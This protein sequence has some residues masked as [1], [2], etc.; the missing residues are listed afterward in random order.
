MIT[1]TL[2]CPYC[3]STDIFNITYKLKSCN[4]CLK[5]FE[6]DVIW[7]IKEYVNNVV[8][9]VGDI[10]VKNVLVIKKGVLYLEEQ[11]F[12]ID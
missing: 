10:A 6:V 5:L 7:H 3:F 12:G 11:V 1:I 2:N 9:N 8:L 4:T